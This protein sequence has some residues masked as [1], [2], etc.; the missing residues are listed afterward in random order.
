MGNLGFLGMMTGMFGVRC[1][2][3]GSSLISGLLAS[4]ASIAFLSWLPLG[5]EEF[6]I[7]GIVIL[8]LSLCKLLKTYDTPMV[9]TLE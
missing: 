8:I 9:C 5:G 1:S 2:A 4:G 6:S 3:C 7:V